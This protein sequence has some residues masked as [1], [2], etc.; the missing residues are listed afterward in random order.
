MDQE[1]TL[2]TSININGSTSKVWE[3]LTNP[4]LIKVYFFGTN[5]ISDWKKGSPILFNGEWEGTAYQDKGT[6]LDVEPEQFVYYNYWSSMSGKPDLP[7]NYAAIRYE[8]TKVGDQTEFRVIQKD[9]K[10][11]ETLEHSLK[12]W[13]MIMDNLKDLVENKMN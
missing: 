2:N 11:K 4:E 12:S 5:C 3:A 1:F 13:E 8:L 9:I 7:E 6:I 10:S